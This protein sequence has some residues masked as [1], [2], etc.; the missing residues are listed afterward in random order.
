MKKGRNAIIKRL[1][2]NS[3]L[4]GGRSPLFY[5]TINTVII[6]SMRD[7]MREEPYVYRDELVSVWDYTKALLLIVIPGFGLLFSLLLAFSK[8]DTGK[9]KNL[10]R[11]ALIVRVVVWIVSIALISVWM[12]EIWPFLQTQLDKYSRLLPLLIGR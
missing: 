1:K 5:G 4:K 6:M 2:L 12:N 10:A 3:L 8:N 11:A 7:F 9:L